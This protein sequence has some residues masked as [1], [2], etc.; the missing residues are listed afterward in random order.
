MP[1]RYAA[2][3]EVQLHSLWTSALEA[4]PGR[5]YSQGKNRR[6]NTDYESERAPSCSGWYGE[7]TII[8]SLRGCE[9]RI[10][11]P[12][13]K[14]RYELRNIISMHTRYCILEMLQIVL[15]TSADAKKKIAA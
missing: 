9:P 12:I 13:A 4:R 11:E 1:W 15:L 3:A 7:E 5:F 2:D 10:V 14:T 6:Y 8:L